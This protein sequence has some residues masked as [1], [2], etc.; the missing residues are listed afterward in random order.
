MGPVLKRTGFK[1]KPRPARQWTAKEPPGPR[2]PVVVPVVDAP[3]A[4]QPKDTPVRSEAYRRYVAALPCWLC[5]VH[6]HSQ[7]AHGDEGKGMALKSSDLT[8]FPLCEPNNG[9]CG[10]HYTV[11]STGTL[12][13]SERRAL[14]TKAAMDTQAALVNMAVGDPAL[15]AVLVKVGL[16]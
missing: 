11:G 6:G 1:P 5:G 16:L 2:T 9:L 10:C 12:T 15:C 4:P 7:A 13:R 8:C 14:E 3:I